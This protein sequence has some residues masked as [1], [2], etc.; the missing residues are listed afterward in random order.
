M[1]LTMIKFGGSLITDKTMAYSLR[2]AIISRLVE[3]VKG[4]CDDG[5]VSHLVLANGAGSFAHQSAALY[6]T[7]GGFSGSKGRFGYC[8]VQHDAARL[9]RMVV[10]VCIEKGL[11]VVSLQPSVMLRTKNKQIEYVD[12]SSVLAAAHAGLIP[13]L[14]GDAILDQSIGSTIYSTDRILNCLTEY[15]KK[16]KGVTVDR[17]IHVGDY[18]GVVDDSGA[19]IPEITKKNYKTIKK[20][21]YETPVVDVTGGMRDKVEEMLAVAK[22]G[23]SS[24]IISGNKEGNLRACL[25]G[26]DFV[27]TKIC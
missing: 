1:N 20:Q 4:I 26:D 8:A 10:G 6:G 11:P 9:N 5:L 24:Y 13:F 16:Q 22:N 3:E 27:G 23:V 7:E 18:D 12:F 19:T 2:F 21:L 25:V 17:I 15:V 14:Y